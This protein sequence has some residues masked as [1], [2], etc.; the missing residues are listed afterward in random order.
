MSTTAYTREM[1]P[2]TKLRHNTGQIPDVP[3]NPRTIRDDRFQMLKNSIQEDPEMI[4]MRELLVYPVDEQFVVIG[5]N[6]RLTAMKDLGY[7]EA[8]CKVLTTATP[9]KKLRAILT[10]D[11][12]A[13]GDFDFLALE[14]WDTDELTQW[15]MEFPKEEENE[16]ESEKY[17][18][19]VGTPVYEPKGD[20]PNIKDLYD[21]TKAI[22]LD[23]EIQNSELPEEI[24][25]FLT[26]AS[27]RHVIFDYGQ[28]AEYYSHAPKEV[29]ELMEKSALVIIDYNQAIENGYVTLTEKL[30]ELQ[31]Q[32]A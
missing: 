19:K 21:T 8:P 11:N 2:L 29:Q 26:L 14:E 22:E 3:K 9:A 15:G 32:H 1:I 7:T 4:E 27:K 25:T 6:M 12:V 5:G 31:K 30:K 20:A 24:K 16:E 18:M 17:T 28:I 13:Y 10:K 23:A